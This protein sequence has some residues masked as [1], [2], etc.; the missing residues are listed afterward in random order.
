M[1]QL[2][3]GHY[4]CNVAQVSLLTVFRERENGAPLTGS[5]YVLKMAARLQPSIPTINVK[6]A[7]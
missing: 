1:L 4:R 3:T 7:A 6:F 2:V 5:R